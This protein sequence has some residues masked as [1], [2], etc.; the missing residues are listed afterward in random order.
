MS[1]WGG[2]PHWEFD[3][4]LLGSDEHGDWI[5]IPVGTFMSRPGAEYVAPTDQVGLVPA[6]GPDERRGWLATFH[7]VGGPV[8]VYVDMTTP[9]V[10]D[11]PVLRTVDLDLDV[12]RGTTGRVWVDDEDEFAEHR[13][14]FGYPEHVAALAMRSCDRVQAAMVAREAPY[15]GSSAAWLAV[16]AAR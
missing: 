8:Q 9:P 7:A 1:K 15:D 14:A 2:R 12:V 10:W 13:V 16:L 11:G 3:A 5:G 4:V 6:A